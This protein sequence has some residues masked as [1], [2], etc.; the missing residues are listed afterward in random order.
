MNIIK[1]VP[2]GVLCF[3][4]SYN[5]LDKLQQ[6]WEMTGIWAEFKKEK[7]VFVGKKSF[8]LS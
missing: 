2:H 8:H 3:M 6:R 4:P 1:K 7:H 5:M